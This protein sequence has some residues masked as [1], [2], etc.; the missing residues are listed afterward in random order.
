MQKAMKE[1]LTAQTFFHH[2]SRSV[3]NRQRECS[4]SQS[5]VVGG[6]ERESD[7]LK[8][9]RR[10]LRPA[11]LSPPITSDIKA[12]TPQRIEGRA[13]FMKSSPAATVATTHAP[14]LT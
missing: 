7:Q 8:L 3:N 4:L 2:I 10:C 5:L 13:G 12:G 1:P 9:K 14:K 6:S 11:L